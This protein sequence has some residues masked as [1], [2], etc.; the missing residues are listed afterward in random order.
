M[1]TGKVHIANPIYDVVF[2]YLMED[3]RVAR[4]V[5]SAI[6]GMEVL[7]LQFSPTE[8]SRKLGDSAITVIRVDFHAR[9]R[10]EDGS[11]HVVLIELQKSKFY[12]QVMRF[13]SYLGRQYQNP[14]HV[15]ASRRPLPIYPIYILAEGFTSSRVPVIRVQRGYTD[16]STGEALLERHPFIEALT[17]DATVIQ[18][19]YLAGRR[20]TELE[21]F[22]SIF[23]QSS[24][25]DARGHMLALVE[26]ECPEAYRPVIR[27][28]QLALANPQLEEDMTLED[29][30]LDEFH[31]K[32]AQLAEAIQLKEEAIQ[33][34]EEAVRRDEVERQ[35]RDT[36]IRRLAAGV[37]AGQIAELTGL[38]ATVVAD[39]LGRADTV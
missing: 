36:L 3:N 19:E 23:D 28:L 22:L 13:G 2:R 30:M 21:R 9:V 33:L 17:H 8:Q 20:Q 27:R 11:E 12:Q 32:D 5:L 16:A 31:H 18:A 38:E 29:E 7:E 6:L 37:S 34:K 4:L 1:S 25:T 15:D 26:E 24:Q 10:Q 35:V 39:V 14:Q